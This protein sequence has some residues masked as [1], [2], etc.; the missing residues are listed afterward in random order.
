MTLENVRG[1]KRIFAAVL[2]INDSVC[3]CDRVRVDFL[4]KTEGITNKKHEWY[5]MQISLEF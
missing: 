2:V 3:Y 5:S 4:L 1:S